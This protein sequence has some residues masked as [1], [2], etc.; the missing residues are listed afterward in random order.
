MCH[1]VLSLFP[2]PPRPH[3][4]GKLPAMSFIYHWHYYVALFLLFVVVVF[5][6]VALHYIQLEI[7]HSRIVEDTFF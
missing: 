7:S 5:L 2:P 4:R 6:P 1:C 3:Q